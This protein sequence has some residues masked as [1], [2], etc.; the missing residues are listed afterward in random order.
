MVHQV[1]FVLGERKRRA[2]NSVLSLSFYRSLSPSVSMYVR[3]CA[4]VSVY[5]KRE[6][7]CSTQFVSYVCV[8]ARF[9]RLLYFLQCCYFGLAISFLLLYLMFFFNTLRCASCMLLLLVLNFSVIRSSCYFPSFCV[10]G[11]LFLYSTHLSI[12]FMLKVRWQLRTS[13]VCILHFRTYI[14]CAAE[15]CVRAKHNSTFNKTR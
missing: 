12:R 1:Y 8:L 7:A 5:V 13:F 9:L 2:G 11:F 15:L 10:F 4:R 3:T 6:S 14:G